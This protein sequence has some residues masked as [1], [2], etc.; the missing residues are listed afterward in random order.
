MLVL[1]IQGTA[2]SRG[3]TQP[4]IDIVDIEKEMPA[5]LNLKDQDIT[6]TAMTIAADYPG[7]YNINQ[8]SKI[9]DS[10]AGSS[11]WFYYNKPIDMF[12]YQSA[13]KTLVLGKALKTIGAGDCNDFAILMSSL[14]QS[15]SGSTRI[16]LSFDSK[17]NTGHAYAEVYLGEKGDPQLNSTLK[18]LQEEYYPNNITGVRY[19]GNEAWLNLDWGKDITTSAYPGGPYFGEWSPDIKDYT[20]WQTDLQKKAPVIVPVIDSME[21]K[22]GW[23]VI[24]D[25]NGSKIGIDIIT[26]KTGSLF[27]LS[28]DLGVNGWVNISKK[29]NNSEFLQ[30]IA[31]LNFSYFSTGSKNTIDLRFVCDDGTTFGAGGSRM[32]EGGGWGFKKMKISNFKC[33]EL[34]NNCDANKKFNLSTVNRMEIII[35]NNPEEGDVEGP[36]TIIIDK[37]RGVMSVPIG[38]P[39]EL[40]EQHKKQNIALDLAAQAS[41]QLKK[42]SINLVIQGT[43]LA[44]ESLRQYE[45]AAGYVAIRNSLSLL[46]RPLKNLKHNGT[47]VAAVFSPDGKKLATASDDNDGNTSRIWDVATG[48]ELH[49]FKHCSYVPSVAFSPDGTKLATACWDN[50]SRIWDV[51]SGDLLHILPHNYSVTSLSFSSDGK[52]LATGSDDNASRIWDV[53]SGDLLHLMYHNNSVQSVLFNPD[54]TKLAS[55]SWDNTTRI[56][57]VES[58]NLLHV[59]PHNDSVTSLSFGPDGKRLATGSDDK[60]ARIWDVENGDLI[61][62]FLHHSTIYTISFSHDGRKLA[63]ASTDSTVRIWDAMSG[64][65]LHMLL[66]YGTVSSLSFSEDDTKLAT[67]CWQ[68]DTVRI[69]G[70]ESGVQLQV[71]NHNAHSVCFSPDGQKL[72]T[73]GGDENARIWSIAGGA[74]LKRLPHNDSVTSVSFN[75]DGN[76]TATGCADGVA[77]IWD[78][79]NEEQLHILPHNDSVSSVSFSPDGKKLATGS[80]DKTA[81][82]WDVKSGDLLHILQHNDSVCSISFSPDGSKLATASLDNTAR[83]WDVNSGSELKKLAH[84]VS[85]SQVSVLFCP[86]G[87]NFVAENHNMGLVTSNLEGS[88]QVLREVLGGVYSVSFSPDGKKLVTAIGDN[89][90]RIWDVASGEKL[91]EFFNDDD[92]YSVSFSPD[93]SKLA[94]SYG[95]HFVQI[96]DVTSGAKLSRLVHDDFVHSISFNHDSSK[97]ATAS[98]DNTVRIWD[99]A[100]GVVLQMV[101]NEGP[102]RCP[103]RSVSFSQNGTIIAGG[104]DKT[105]R[106]WIVNKEDII[107]DAC[108]RLTKNMTET[109]WKRYLSMDDCM[110]C[111]SEGRFEE[112]SQNCIP[113]IESLSG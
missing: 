113:C 15:I 45:T 42:P 9:Y 55:A 4:T 88:F 99:V 105:A 100:R 54:G 1:F 107:N 104:N 65:E 21:S 41:E 2:Q 102:A 64:K 39:W 95:P 3:T 16:N 26:G 29:L 59:L 14:I 5:K 93:G 20:I 7:A 84:D 13:S 77:I 63:T 17:N 25:K 33:V 61:H 24:N 31:A 35:Y 71:L 89:T 109:E 68:D 19:T 48:K 106:I 52:R 97:L 112:S 108:D 60:T 37:I 56:W 94:A 58:G 18:W 78:A 79:M 80:A 47:V 11:G 73:G 74:E 72:A 103:V 38:S 6:Y 90:I 82:I 87:R 81:R 28:Y 101:V 36:G 86:D 8:I 62:V 66:H 53:E 44:V 32:K 23:Q 96:W 111:P 76:M 98:S 22:E 34:G 67:A 43:S 69:W 50:E 91:Q 12:N 30:Q 85:N 83:V 10:L 40:A 92:V 57:G 49:R 70:V 75:P 51:E 46:P 27:Q 110:T